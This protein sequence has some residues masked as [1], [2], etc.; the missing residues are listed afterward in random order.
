MF[1]NVK[2]FFFNISVDFFL[3][4]STFTVVQL[5]LRAYFIL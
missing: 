1:L 4:L 3:T 5:K 2:T